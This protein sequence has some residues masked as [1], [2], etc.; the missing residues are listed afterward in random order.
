MCEFTDQIHTITAIMPKDT[1]SEMI[2]K[3]YFLTMLFSLQ[4]I[5]K[6]GA[7]TLKNDLRTKK[8]VFGYVSLINIT[9]ITCLLKY[10]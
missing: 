4:K 9:F 7:K 10:I 2:L 1:Y 3:Y 5:V 6:E 8:M